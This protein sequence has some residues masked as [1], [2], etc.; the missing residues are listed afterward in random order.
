[1]CKL[2]LIDLIDSG[3][4]FLYNFTFDVPRIEPVRSN[5]ALY[6]TVSRLSQKLL[7]FCLSYMMSS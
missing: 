6:W 5:A 2:Y 7:L 4:N 3:S 1:M